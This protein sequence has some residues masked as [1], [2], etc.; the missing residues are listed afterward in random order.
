MLPSE[1]SNDES[2]LTAAVAIIVDPLGAQMR[3]LQ[4]AVRF[5]AA[6]GQVATQ[7]WMKS[8]KKLQ[9]TCCSLH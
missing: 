4:R 6:H 8:L 2:C 1:D 9:L 3:D 7:W 5:V